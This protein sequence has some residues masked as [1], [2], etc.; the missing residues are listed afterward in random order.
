MCEANI[1]NVEN[2][3]H[4]SCMNLDEVRRVCDYLQ[5]VIELM[6]EH[7]LA[8]TVSDICN[9]Y[10]GFRKEYLRMSV[11]LHPDKGG[12]ETDFQSLND[13]N[14]FVNNYVHDAEHRDCCVRFVHMYYVDPEDVNRQIDAQIDKQQQ[15][16][17]SQSKKK[18]SAPAPTN[19]SAHS[20]S[21]AS[22][23]PKKKK[24]NVSNGN[25]KTTSKKDKK[26]KQN[27]TPAVVPTKVLKK[28]HTL[29]KFV[30]TLQ[31]LVDTVLSTFYPELYPDGFKVTIDCTFQLLN[32]GKK[33]MSEMTYK[34]VLRMKNRTIQ[35]AYMSMFGD[36]E[37]YTENIKQNS[38]VSQWKNNLGLTNK[39][40][41]YEGSKKATTLKIVSP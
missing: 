3:K 38:W 9:P 16:S 18:T 26:R 10:F 12:N 30:S 20:S 15:K 29:D 27:K 7:G 5:R 13:V 28:T 17:N 21:F 35:E 25:K 22:S 32:D 2:A 24:E 19:G 14:D 41:K 31:N 8:V 6:Q 11:K 4:T 1:S 40:D 23:A 39:N 37:F 33:K 36:I 34:R